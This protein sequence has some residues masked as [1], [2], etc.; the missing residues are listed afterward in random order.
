MKIRPWRVTVCL[1]FAMALSAAAASAYAAGNYAV[2]QKQVEGHATYHLLDNKRHM[3]FGLAPDMGNFAY[4]FK[5]NGQNVLIPPDS[6]K[7][8]L[9]KHTFCCGIP[10]LA[11]Y[12]NR[13][14]QDAYYFQNQKYILNPALGNVFRDNFGQPMHGLV[15]FEKRWKVV[16]TG[17]TDDQGAFVTSRLD[18]YKY[19]DLIAQFPFANTIEVTYR[20]K[21]GKLQNSTVIHNLGASPMPVLIGYHPYFLPLGPRADWVVHLGV[22]EHLLLNSKLIP[23]GQTEPATRVLP[24]P[25][26][27]KLTS[28]ELDEVFTGLKRDAQGLA[29]LAVQGQKGRIE[30]VYG[31]P[32]TYA[33]VYAPR[34]ADLICME[35]Q[36]GPTDAFNLNHEGKFPGLIVLGAGK[37]FEASFWIVPTGY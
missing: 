18:F 1:L 4:Q 24:D 23:T 25:E 21:D 26:N 28:M 15:V 35:P 33:V 34:P 10:F 29:H 14:D 2:A 16:R 30:V 8:Y 5:V 37:T 3:D 31:K 19:P 7:G 6:F 20:L 11:P 27:A 13:I 22:T 9:A 12:A 17:A 36:T 32:Y